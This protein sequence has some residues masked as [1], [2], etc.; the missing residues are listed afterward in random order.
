L[1]S[2]HSECHPKWD[3]TKPT[4]SGIIDTHDEIPISTIHEVPPSRH[5]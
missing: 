1:S 5:K 2:M 3:D 4:S